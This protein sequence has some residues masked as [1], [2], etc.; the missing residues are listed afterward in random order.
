MANVQGMTSLP[1]TKI[2]KTHVSVYVK[3]QKEFETQIWATEETNIKQIEELEQDMELLKRLKD[4]VTSQS[5][6]SKQPRN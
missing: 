5:N 1:F 6:I 3:Q 2:Q 4:T